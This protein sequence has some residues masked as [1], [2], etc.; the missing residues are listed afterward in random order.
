M[1]VRSDQRNITLTM[2]EHALG[3]AKRGFHVFPIYEMTADGHCSCS[4]PKPCVRDVPGK[5]PRIKNNLALST[6][7]ERQIREWWTRWP[8]ANI[9]I[10]TGTELPD[11]GY[12]MVL[13]TDPRHDGDQTLHLLEDKYGSL[14]ETPRNLTGGIGGEHRYLRVQ[15]PI[16]SSAGELGVGRGVDVKCLGGYVIAPPSNHKSGRRYECDAGA[17]FDDVPIAQAPEWLLVL[18]DR[19]KGPSKSTP[20]TADVFIEGGRHNAILSMAGVMRR[21]GLLPSEMLPTLLALNE[22]RCRPP[23]DGSAVRSIAESS[24][25]APQDP[26][27]AND[28]WNLMT[29]EQIFAP[30]PPYP[31]LIKGLHV[32]PGR[33]TLLCGYAD[34]GKTVIAMTWALSVASGRPVWDVFHPDQSGRVLHLNGEIGSYIA[35]E[36]YQR[37][38]RGAAVDESALIDSGALVLANYPNVRL[39]DRDFE[40]KL[41]LQCEGFRLV[42]ID[43][44]RAFSG[45][46][47]EKAKEIGVAL[48]MLARVSQATGATIVV[49]HHNRKP[50]KDDVGGAKMAI[51]G[52]SS[53]LGGAECAFV[54]TSTEKGGPILVQHERSPVGN[55]MPDFGLKIEDVSQGADPRWGLRVVHLEP[56]QLAE[57][58]ERAEA[59]R[60]KVVVEKAKLA[61][62]GVLERTAGVYRGSQEQF[63]AMAGVGKGPF[64]R[65]LSELYSDG[66]VE[67]AGKY[68]NPEWHLT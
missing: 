5:H 4:A 52:S 28:P 49:L 22:G 51:S 40:A 60:D 45:A 56:E 1:T 11:G 17:D 15:K 27:A 18:A 44:L 21:K 43:S 14:P 63:R 16:G 65:A 24:T 23:L 33:I 12:L 47:D 42:I 30:L 7:D 25:W 41:A 26:L 54:M 46:L 8:N 9:G 32:A 68:H 29:T 55:L 2:L 36:R 35:R 50:S 64:A 62:I 38:A 19:P 6:T 61:V 58:S 20:A 39:D 59:A 34:V 10:A 48:L 3:W 67:K 31:W 37:L 13:D 53:I 66:R 57:L